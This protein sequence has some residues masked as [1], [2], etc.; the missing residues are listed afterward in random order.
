MMPRGAKLIN[1]ARGPL[2][3]EPALIAALRSGHVAEATL[4]AFA[5]EP[6]PPEHPL[7]TFE[8]VLITPHLASITVPRERRATLPKAF[9]ACAP[10]AAAACCRPLARL[11]IRLPKLDRKSLFRG[12]ENNILPTPVHTARSRFNWRLR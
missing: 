4:D 3:D 1:A 6:L 9:V 2:V 11:L 12:P 7:W 10:E 5:V 8:N